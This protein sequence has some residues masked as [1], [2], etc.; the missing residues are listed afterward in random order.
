MS[1]AR[2]EDIQVNALSKTLLGL[3]LLSWLA[4]LRPQ[5]SAPAHLV[6][7]TSGAHLGP[8]ITSWASYHSEG[9]ILEQFS[10]EENWQGS[11]PNYAVSKLI[12]Q[13]A[14]GEIAKMVLSP[15]GESVPLVSSGGVVDFELTDETS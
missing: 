3:M 13:Y 2:E 14:V 15:S 4:S 11:I 9:G 7:V 8:D 6:F 10:K 1:A 5:R 12:A